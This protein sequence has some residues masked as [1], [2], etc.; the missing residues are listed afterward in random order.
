[1][2]RLTTKFGTSEKICHAWQQH[3]ARLKIFGTS[4]KKKFGMSDNKIWHACQQNLA[5]RDKNVATSD[6]KIPV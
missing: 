5:H 1:L 4:G 2:A 6:N 3:L